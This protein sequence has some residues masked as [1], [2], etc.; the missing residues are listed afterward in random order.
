MSCWHSYQQ[1][2]SPTL[3]GKSPKTHRQT[4]PDLA[5]AFA[6]NGAPRGVQAVPTN[7]LS[8]VVA[9]PVP[10]AAVV[11]TRAELVP[12][13]RCASALVAPFWSVQDEPYASVP[14]ALIECVPAEPF[15]TSP[16]AP[17]EFAPV[18]L[19]ERVPGVA[20]RNCALSLSA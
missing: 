13:V 12:D 5:I 17:S 2:V 4:T 16:D 19:C 7:F 20:R 9:Q 6:V 15:V 10:G 18:V 11:T 14:G 1:V 8:D 3:P